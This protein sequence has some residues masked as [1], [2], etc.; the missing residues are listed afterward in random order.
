[1]KRMKFEVIHAAAPGAFTA[2]VEGVVY[3]GEK[4]NVAG[5]E[6]PIVVDFAGLALPESVPLL[7]DHRNETEFRVGTV[8]AQ[9]RDNAL[10]ASG[11]I[12]ESNDKART[13]IEQARAGAEW[14]LSIGAAVLECAFVEPGA[15]V[16]INGR[17]Q[18]GPFYHIQKSKLNEISVV[19]VGADSDTK[20]NIA[21]KATLKTG[22]KHMSKDETTKNVQAAG[23]E[24]P[25]AVQ[26]TKPENKNAEP[27]IQAAKAEPKPETAAP[28]IQAAKAEREKALNNLF[29][30]EFPEIRAAA[31]AEGWSLEKAQSKLIEAIRAN[32][33]SAGTLGIVTGNHSAAPGAVIEAA[34]LMAGGIPADDVAKHCPA[35]VVEAAQKRYRSGISLQQMILEAAWA[36]GYTDR[37]IG[38]GNWAEA[39]QYAGIVKAAFSNVNLPGVMSNVANKFLLTGFSAVDESWKAI[40]ATRSVKDFKT[41]TNYRLG[42]D[43]K[44]RKVAETGEL[45]SG[46]MSERSF[47]NQA[48]TYGMIIAITRKDIINDD[49]GA[50]TRIPEMMGYAAG[51]SF[52]EIFW[53]EFLDNAAFFTA[54]NKNLV[55]S[56]ALSIAGLNAGIKAFRDLKDESGHRTGITPKTLLVPSAL[57][58]TARELYQATTLIAAGV[59]NSKNLVPNTNIHA[60][61]YAPVVSP[62]LDDT[63]YT[64]ASATTWYLLGDPRVRAVIEAVFLNG[65]QT[66]TIESSAV[67]FDKLGVQMRGYMDF[68]VSKQDFLGGVKVTA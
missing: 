68:G 32:R 49:L 62:Y 16:E 57:E 54:D 7:A 10:Y 18:E 5:F 45:K 11:V 8:K 66:P 40:A 15:S 3:H 50:L 37:F 36:N 4:M 27:G 38:T 43:F 34:A 56:S 60:G 25:A 48:D 47:T 29:G 44:F 20:L 28:D 65:I 17:T 6:A 23:Q 1:M 13:I 53:T 41:V 31:I 26:A 42:N 55:E 61:K 63:E 46:S 67:E 12:C 2:K 59:G 39:L 52:N 35:P 51:Q 19:P 64:G 22:E 14:Q 9:A 58:A 30:D 33:P 24:A 21:A